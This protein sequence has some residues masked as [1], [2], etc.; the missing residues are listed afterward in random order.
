MKQKKYIATERQRDNER[1]RDID[2]EAE[3]HKN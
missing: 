2:K 3:G 1:E